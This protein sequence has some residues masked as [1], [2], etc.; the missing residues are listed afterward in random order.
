MLVRVVRARR[1]QGGGAVERVGAV[2]AAEVGMVGLASVHGGELG[3][4]DGPRRHCHPPSSVRRAGDV[5]ED[6]VPQ[7]SWVI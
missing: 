7:P 4:S 3:H 5:S 6:R 2:C 1:E